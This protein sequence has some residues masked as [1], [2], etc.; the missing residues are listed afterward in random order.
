MFLKPSRQINQKV[1]SKSTLLWGKHISAFCCGFVGTPPEETLWPSR[2]SNQKLM[3]QAKKKKQ[4]EKRTENQQTSGVWRPSTSERSCHRPS[5]GLWWIYLC[6]GS[7]LKPSQLGII[8]CFGKASKPRT[9]SNYCLNEKTNKGTKAVCLQG[10]RLC[11]QR[12]RK[13]NV[14]WCPLLFSTRSLFV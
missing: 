6:I 3:M 2:V 14:A 13:L 1:K 8:T 7:G 9:Q 11:K 5:T 10:L 12:V 4:K